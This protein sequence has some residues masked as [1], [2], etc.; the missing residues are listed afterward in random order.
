MTTFSDSLFSAIGGWQNGWREI[1][2]R[3]EELANTLKAEAVSL[4]PEFRCAEGPCYRKR[5]IHKGEL[6]DLILKNERDEGI[7]SWTTDAKFAERFK[8]LIRPDAVSAAIFCHTPAPNEVVV[9]I[10]AL[11]QSQEFIEAAEGFKKKN[12][13]N[14]EALFHFRDAQGE[15]VLHAPLR[16]SEI[17][18]LTGISSPFDELCDKANIAEERRDAIFRKLIADGTYPGEPGYTTVAGA[19]NVIAKTIKAMHKKLEL[20]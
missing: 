5:F 13:T 15:V 20:L 8:G 11:W 10:G 18:G 6:V 14:S 16:G 4:P 7:T 19:Q 3:R 17:I 1:Q 2:S 9:N 12:G